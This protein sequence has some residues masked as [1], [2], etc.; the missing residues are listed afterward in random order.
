[1]LLCYFGLVEAGEKWSKG[2]G[3]WVGWGGWG[4]VYI[5]KNESCLEVYNFCN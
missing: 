5:G 2:C 3:S 4:D 1:M